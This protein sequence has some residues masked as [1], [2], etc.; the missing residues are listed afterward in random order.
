MLCDVFYRRSRTYLPLHIT[1]LFNVST[2]A[3]VY[4]VFLFFSF[5]VIVFSAVNIMYVGRPAFSWFHVLAI[6]PDRGV[7]EFS[8]YYGA[9]VFCCLY[10]M[11]FVCLFFVG[12]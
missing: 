5:Y 9:S 1:R 10:L 4:L 6:F 7:F 3:F 2:S 11:F 8:F 12:V